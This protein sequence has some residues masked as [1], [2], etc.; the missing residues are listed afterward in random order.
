MAA[1]SNRFRSKRVDPLNL[2]ICPDHARKIR[3]F[4]GTCLEFAPKGFLEMILTDL[5]AS[6]RAA[7][8]RPYRA[9][10]LQNN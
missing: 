4:D 10:L 9:E 8:L 7:L 2:K 1:D 5:M 6:L 3:N